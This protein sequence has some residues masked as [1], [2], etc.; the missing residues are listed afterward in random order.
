[1]RVVAVIGPAAAQV[2]QLSGLPAVHDAELLTNVVREGIA[3]FF[4]VD[5]VLP[6]TTSVYRD[7][8][9]TTWCAAFDRTTIDALTRACDVASARLVAVAPVVAML[10]GVLGDGIHVWSDGDVHVELGV[11]HGALAGMTRRHTGGA[12]IAMR[13]SW[14]ETIDVDVARRLSPRTPLVW[15][16]GQAERRNRL[17]RRRLLGI[18]AVASLAGL[19]AFIAPTAH[20]L[21]SGAAAKADVEEM[22]V[23]RNGVAQTT[24]A[25][26]GVTQDLDRIESFTAERR[27]MSFL[28]R[29]L[30]I[31]LP[32]STA[33]V[34]IRIDSAGASGSAVAPHAADIVLA[35]T[36]VDG[37]VLP[38]LVGAVTRETV[39]G[40]R[41]ERAAIR[42]RLPAKSHA[43]HVAP[44]PRAGS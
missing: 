37:V 27:P 13:G 18:V 11:R 25:L 23:V 40:V 42:F 12:S 21:A 33:I 17:R 43:V 7:G 39:G 44:M 3:H 19:S 31:A 35:L 29:D 36:G 4:L 15:R 28:L 8:S 20:L 1:M 30:T 22:A 41:L 6:V 16:P 14:T 32:E 24:A 38:R 34:S 5:A 9:G 10:P 26:I 2:K